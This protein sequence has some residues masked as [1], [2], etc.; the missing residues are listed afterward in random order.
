MGPHV[1][2]DAIDF[3]NDGH[4]LLTGSYRLE[5]ALQLWDLRTNKEVREINWNG[6]KIQENSDFIPSPSIVVSI[7]DDAEPEAP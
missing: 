3:R 1:C 2:G 6:P 4:T 7:F 5:K